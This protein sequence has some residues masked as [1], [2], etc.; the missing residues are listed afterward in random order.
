MN[1][2]T[3]SPQPGLVS[4]TLTSQHGKNLGQTNIKYYGQQEV[5][6]KIVRSPFLVKKL[7]EEY[8]M[9]YGFGETGETDIEALNSRILGKLNLVN[10]FTVLGISWKWEKLLCVTA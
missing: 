5:V 1:F 2:A 6:K 8:S 7:C 9:V 10:S 3:A 4:V